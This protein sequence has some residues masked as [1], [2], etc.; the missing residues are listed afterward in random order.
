MISTA[1]AI[2]ILAHLLMCSAN[3]VTIKTNGTVTEVCKNECEQVCKDCKPQEQC[4]ETEV[5][6]G[7]D[8][9]NPYDDVCPAKKVCVEKGYNCKYIILPFIY[10]YFIYTATLLKSIRLI[11]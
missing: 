2:A 3:E 1:S 7:D 10:A 4:K 9:N 8:P 5:D 11:K 6:C